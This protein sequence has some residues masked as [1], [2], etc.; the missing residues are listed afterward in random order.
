MTRYIVVPYAVCIVRITVDADSMEEAI[1]IA[2]SQEHGNVIRNAIDC[3][4]AEYVD[5]INGVLV[6]VV[7]DK[8]YKLS[9]YFEQNGDD[10]K[11]LVRQGDA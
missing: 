10:S 2:L 6:D 7:G 5:E 8:E 9:K 11:W 3:G 1:D 4:T